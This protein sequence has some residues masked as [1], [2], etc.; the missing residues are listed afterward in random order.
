[1]WIKIN[2]TGQVEDFVDEFARAAIN[3]G[4][5][6]KVDGP[7]K[8]GVEVAAVTPRQETASLATPTFRRG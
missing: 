7:K 3:Q 6:T 2:A 8:S 4:I 1:M 5:A